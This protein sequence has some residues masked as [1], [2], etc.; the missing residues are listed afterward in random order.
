MT[1]ELRDTGFLHAILVTTALQRAIDSG[2]A[3]RGALFHS[4]RG[5]QYRAA[6]T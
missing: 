6:L 1:Q 4:D 3:A 2:Q 5:C